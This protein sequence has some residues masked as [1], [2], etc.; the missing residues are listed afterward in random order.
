MPSRPTESKIVVLVEPDAAHREA[1]RAALA[2]AGFRVLDFPNYLGALDEVESGRPI[3]L[4]ITD[5]HLPA[6]TPH[7]LS[8]VAM[9]QLRRPRLRAMFLTN[10][11]DRYPLLDQN[12]VLQRPFA[13]A[14]L[15]TTV[16]N[17]IG[18]TPKDT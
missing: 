18:D 16:K 4:L 13:A 10:A 14:T 15:M 7:G 3:D 12:S 2:E 9:V 17:L 1:H 5:V 11:E 6:G 8:L